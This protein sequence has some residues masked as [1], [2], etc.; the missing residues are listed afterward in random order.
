MRI[1]ADT[2]AHWYDT[3][4]S[5]VFLRH[6]LSN[7]RARAAEV[8]ANGTAAD[9]RGVLCLA[10]RAGESR[11]AA[12]RAGRGIPPGFRV[13]PLA[14]PAA[15]RIG[16]KSGAALWLVAGRQIVPRERIEVLALGAD[17][18][19]PDGETL[20]DTLAAVRAGGAWPAIAWAPGKWWF[21]R[22][23]LLRALLAR[24]APSEFAL[25]DSPMRPVGWPE[26]RLMTLARARG[27]R[28]VAGSDPL[29]PPGEERQ[30]ARYV[31]A[32]DAPFDDTR[33]AS[34]LRAALASGRPPRLVGRRGTSRET[35]R[36]WQAHRRW[37]R[38]A[39]RRTPP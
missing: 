28:V 25:G 14:E 18:D 1:I 35:W 33:P 37:K 5:E 10:E 2:H 3:Y 21:G 15:V 12:L 9:W 11:F 39:E 16:D 24:S 29:P 22:G 20:A 27:F 38:G 4:A 19:I 26:P 30:A 23:R 6:A 17:P 8:A 32:F 31:C 34:S 13:E 36:R 7:L